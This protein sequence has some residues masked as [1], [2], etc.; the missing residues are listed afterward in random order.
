MTNE[1]CLSNLL[2]KWEENFERGQDIPAENLCQDRPDLAPILASRIGA[3]KKIA[4]MKAAPGCAEVAAHS[5]SPGQDCCSRQDERPDPPSLLAGRYRLDC[6][7]GEGG[8]GQVWRGFDMEL[9]RLVAVKVPKPGNL[10][11][12]E[13][14]QGFLAEA[15]KVARLKHPVIVPVYDVGRHG[16][17]YFIVSELIEGTDLAERMRQ[18]RLPVREAIRIVAAVA[19]GL[20]YAHR[21]G[22][23]HQDVKP[24]NVLLGA[25]P[26]D[27]PAVIGEVWVPA[28]L[29]GG[30]V[31]QVH[32]TDFGIAFDRA[33]MTGA[34]GDVAGTLAYMSPEQV[35]GDRSKMD[36][37]S[38]IYS[39]GVML[40]ELVTG[41][42][43]P[44]AVHPVQA[45]EPWPSSPLS[46]GGQVPSFLSQVWRKC[47]AKD[48]ADRYLTAND[49]AENL[50]R[51]VEV[52]LEEEEWAAGT[53][54]MEM[55]RQVYECASPRKMRLFFCACF[56]QHF[57]GLENE[58]S[59]LAIEVAERHADGRATNEEL[60]LA[61]AAAREASKE[62][63]ETWEQP[64][65][66]LWATY[67]E[68]WTAAFNVSRHTEA[69]LQCR[70]L[71]ELFG[72]SVYRPV[73][74]HPAWLSWNGGTVH[75]IAQGIYD[76]RAF[77]RLPIL[78]DALEEA[79][80]DNADILAHCREPGIHCR[81]CW[82]VDAVLGLE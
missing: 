10:A 34:E 41:F 25:E 65:A 62:W 12:Q 48:P 42:R 4:W 38:D 68:V 33:A 22:I 43:P 80:C 2:L 40:C 1:E 36:H 60:R 66:A 56:R 61:H 77:D 58:R 7:L 49:L 17:S 47:M 9:Q 46:S 75:S 20:E 39:L 29:L 5:G 3:L 16:Q 74:L 15:R 28:H 82:V 11:D 63:V 81:G 59:R 52:A 37:R 70:L 72:P 64:R 31:Q 71:R 79:G 44:P 45:R 54:A 57:P 69:E 6:L 53:D 26:G 19:Y 30:D 24:A 51:A 27:V 21:Q 23:I 76:D 73:L 32:L 67:Q 13:K 55:L 50:R 8:F 35:S 14:V 78:A 18:G